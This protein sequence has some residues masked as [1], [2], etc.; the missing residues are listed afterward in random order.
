M[1][2]QTLQTRDRV[3][4]LEK[5]VKN[6]SAI[7]LEMC[8]KN[9]VITGLR[10]Q[11]IRHFLKCCSSVLSG[12]NKKKRQSILLKTNR[13]TELEPAGHNKWGNVLY[14]YLCECGTVCIKIRSTVTRNRTKSCGCLMREY[15][16]EFIKKYRKSFPKGNKLSTLHKTGK[17]NANKGRVVIWPEGVSRGGKAGLIKGCKFVSEEELN[18]MFWGLD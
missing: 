10:S 7:I 13:L 18:A 16:E 12:N 15:R 4:A 3:D 8:G 2:K 14:S 1:T 6:L 11:S 5:E 17:P 9:L